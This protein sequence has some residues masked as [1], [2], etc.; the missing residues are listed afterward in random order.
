MHKLIRTGTFALLTFIV[1]MGLLTLTASAKDQDLSYVD[2]NQD[3]T[4]YINA[5]AEVHPVGG[6]AS[7]WSTLV[8][9]KD[10]AY[11]DVLGM[12]LEKRG[13]NPGQLEYVQ[14]LQEV[15]CST[16]AIDT[17]NVL[18]YDKQDRIVLEVNSQV[19]AQLIAEFG[20]AEDS[21]LTAVC[22]QHVANL[23]GEQEMER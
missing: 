11:Y 9:K 12:S 14:L 5:R 10:G 20:Q 2:A 17:S 7:F 16:W 22:S 3:G 18:F 8:P 15:D 4:W 13:K 23:T 6:K 19:P 1:F 21:L